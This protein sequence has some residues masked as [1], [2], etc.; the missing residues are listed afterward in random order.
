M[1]TALCLTVIHGR[2]FLMKNKFF[3]L[4]VAGVLV[5]PTIVAVANYMSTANQ[6]ANAKNSVRITI[7]DLSGVPH[8]MERKADGDEADKMIDLICD[9]NSSARN[10]RI[11][12]LPDAVASGKYF[13]VVLRLSKRRNLNKE[14][15]SFSR[16]ATM[17]GKGGALGS[18]SSTLL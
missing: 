15:Y 1:L 11:P 12:A 14:M 3:A 17:F 18:V 5:I 6:P 9:I 4:L 2:K 10:N 13:R 16:P 7:T 8:A